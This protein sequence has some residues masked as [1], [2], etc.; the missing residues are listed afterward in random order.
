VRRNDGDNSRE[1]GAKSRIDAVRREHQ[2]VSKEEAAM[3]P[4]GR[5]RNRR[6]HRNLAA[7]RR[8]NPKKSPRG[9]VDRG[10]DYRCRLED[11]TPCRSGMAQEKRR[12]ERSDQGAG[13]R[14]APKG[15]EEISTSLLLGGCVRTCLLGRYLAM[16]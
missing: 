14:R 11:D 10:R 7:E 1:D 15:R 5:L 12:Q 9:I 4:V 8:Q 16:L 3:K 2:E 6:R 13:E